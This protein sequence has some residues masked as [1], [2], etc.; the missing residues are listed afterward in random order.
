MLEMV[1]SWLLSVYD[2]CGVK[3]V[4]PAIPYSEWAIARPDRK[5]GYEEQW[6]PYKCNLQHTSLG[7]H[8]NDI[9]TVRAVWERFTDNRQA[10]ALHSP[11]EIGIG[12]TSSDIIGVR[13]M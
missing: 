12:K 1:P 10:V 7:I 11:S 6:K 9:E 13:S 4:W 5:Q 2:L 8:Y 3:L